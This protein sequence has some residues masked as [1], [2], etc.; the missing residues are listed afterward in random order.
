VVPGQA[1]KLGYRFAFDEVGAA[2]EDLL[3]R[4]RTREEA[5]SSSTP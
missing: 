4:G 1:A 3:G 2:L 5:A